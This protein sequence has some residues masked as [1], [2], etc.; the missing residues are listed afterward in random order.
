MWMF[1]LLCICIPCTCIIHRNQ[2]K[3]SSLHDLEFQTIMSCHVGTRNRTW[4]RATSEPSL[5][6]FPKCHFLFLWPRAIKLLD[7]GVGFFFYKIANST[8]FYYS[9]TK[10]VIKNER[11]HVKFWYLAFMIQAANMPVIFIIISSLQ[12]RKLVL[13]R[14]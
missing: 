3:E 7:L 1:C 14:S 2:R 10:N 9:S 13:S 6:I 5:P 4:V 12:V 8:T 11:Q